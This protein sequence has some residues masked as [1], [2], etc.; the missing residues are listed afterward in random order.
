[1]ELNAVRFNVVEFNVLE[2]NSSEC[3]L[4]ETEEREKKVRQCVSVAWVFIIFR[5]QNAHT[6]NHTLHP[7]PSVHAR[8]LATSQG[9]LILSHRFE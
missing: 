6:H 5:I 7:N 1:M 8:T 9:F 2:L 4:L 3:L